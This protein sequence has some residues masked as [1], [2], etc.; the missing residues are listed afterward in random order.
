GALLFNVMPIFLGGTAERFGLDNAQLGWLGSAYLAGF[1]MVS[2]TA[3][4]WIERF[5]WRRLT[6]LSLVLAGASLAA[7]ALV[8]GYYWLLVTLLLAGIGCGVFYTVGI[9]I[10]AGNHNPDR[11]FAFKMVSETL[12]GVL[13][14]VALPTLVYQ[15]WGFVGVALT[16]AVLLV[17]FGG[18]A[19]YG[20]PRGRSGTVDAMALVSA[21]STKTSRTAWFGLFALGLHFGVVTAL[22]AFL[23]RVSGEFGVDTQQAGQVLM[24]A[25]AL[26]G[27]LALV[28][29]ALCTRIGRV[30]PLLFGMG[31]MV[32][33]VVILA[34]RHDL[35]GYGLG[36]LLVVG[37]WALVMSYQMGV[38]ASA[39]RS[40]RVA[41]LIPAAITGGGAVG[42]GVAGMLV[43]GSDYAPLYGLF[44]L[45]TLASLLIFL[46]IVRYLK[47][48]DGDAGPL[49]VL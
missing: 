43:Q 48:R 30:A 2:A 23:E 1:A 7:C 44:V 45:A 42:P 19:L 36:A 26:N 10:L 16:L 4:I 22:W 9:A 6:Q 39:D 46:W 41:V 33:G 3:M 12:S 28:A 35:L 17:L 18:L 21:G 32:L 27:L 29:A 24:L 40:G 38:I 25:M 20:T 11:A 8:E 47:R 31:S 37:N 15:R 49:A 5:D 34:S 14:L 13:L